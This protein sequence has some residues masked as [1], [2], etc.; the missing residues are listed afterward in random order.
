MTAGEI[1]MLAADHRRWNQTFYQKT[2]YSGVTVVP[3]PADINA[4]IRTY[5]NTHG[6]GMHADYA[7][8]VAAAYL[9]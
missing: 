2:A 1:A 7:W 9:N 8:R 4:L 6:S 3:A 5:R